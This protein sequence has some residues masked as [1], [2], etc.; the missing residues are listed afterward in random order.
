MHKLLVA[1]LC[2][3]KFNEVNLNTLFQ[4]C[5]CSQI[6]LIYQ[7]VLYPSFTQ[8]QLN[9]AIPLYEI[10][11]S[12]NHKHQTFVMISCNAHLSEK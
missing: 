9:S 5:K 10:A 2:I 8:V 6:N 4:A 12:S 11:R 7:V 3:R 1:D